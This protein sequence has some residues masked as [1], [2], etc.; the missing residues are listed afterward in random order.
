MFVLGRR[1]QKPASLNVNKKTLIYLESVSFPCLLIY[2]GYLPP[3]LP[4]KHPNIKRCLQTF[5]EGQSS[6]SGCPV[7]SIIVLLATKQN[8][9]TA[10][11]LENEEVWVEVSPPEEW[12]SK[13]GEGEREA[14][15]LG[16]HAKKLLQKFKEGVRLRMPLKFHFWPHRNNKWPAISLKGFNEEINTGVKLIELLHTIC[17]FNCFDFHWIYCNWR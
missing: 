4:Q 12:R 1:M 17:A 9:R 5:C 6:S 8:W 13:H 7:F 3:S 10:L 11:A 2:Q 15:A 14:L 16:S